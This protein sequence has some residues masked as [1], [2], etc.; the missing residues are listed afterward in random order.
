MNEVLWGS[1]VRAD[2]YIIIIII[3]ILWSAALTFSPPPCF[4]FLSLNSPFWNTLLFL[5]DILYIYEHKKQ[6]F[7]RN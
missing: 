3:I 6:E 4:F 7:I 5:F 2:R 1:Q